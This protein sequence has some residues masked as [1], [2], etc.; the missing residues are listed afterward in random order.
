MAAPGLRQGLGVTNHAE[1]DAVRMKPHLLLKKAMKKPT[2]LA[3]GLMSQFYLF[4][5]MHDEALAEIERAVAMDPNDPELYTW[6]SD[7]LWFMGKNSEA[8]ESAKMGQRLDPNNPA[9]YL[10]QLGKVYFPDGNL[11]ESLQL[12]EKAKKLNPDLS[13]SVAFHQAIIYGI[14]GRTEEART[15]YEIFLKNRMTPVR[16]LKDL[17]SYFPFADPKKRDSFAAVLIQAGVPGNPTDYHKII[18]GKP[19]QRT[20]GQIA[21]FRSKDYWNLYV[22]R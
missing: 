19:D 18:K 2:A 13:G 5:Y 7:I 17:M 6:M 9:A 3:H 12:L 20:G 8:I 1:L 10:N 14:Q 11:Q 15:A 21:S 4:R 16:S 22:N